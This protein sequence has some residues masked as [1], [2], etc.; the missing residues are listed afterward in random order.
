MPK[1]KTRKAV[2]KRVKITGTGK[3]RH[4][5]AGKRHLQVNKNSKRKRNLRGDAAVS[6]AD[7]N[8]IKA[9]LP[10]GL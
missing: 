2:V 5:R 8:R 3:I 10:Y 9:C 4:Y 6:K 1:Q 7:S